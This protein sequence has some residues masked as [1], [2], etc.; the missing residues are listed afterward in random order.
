[1]DAVRPQQSGGSESV[2]GTGLLRRTLRSHSLSC[3][4]WHTGCSQTNINNRVNS[5][6][7]AE[8]RRL[9]SPRAIQSGWM[10]REKRREK[11]FFLLTLSAN[12]HNIYK[13]TLLTTSTRK[14][15]GTQST[16]EGIKEKQ[17]MLLLI[18]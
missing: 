13:A 15:I 18:K 4:R 6:M 3:A 7:K 2:V 14:I 16:F 10:R 12:S 8:W 17:Y 1:M 9:I 5:Q 11:V